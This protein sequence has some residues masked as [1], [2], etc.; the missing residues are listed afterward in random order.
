MAAL[1]LAQR[2]PTSRSPQRQ[3][4]SDCNRS[5]RRNAAVIDSRR[6]GIGL[7]FAQLEAPPAQRHGRQA[8]EGE[9]GA[10][11]ALSTRTLEEKRER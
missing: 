9:A 8:H 7:R 3:G 1:L 4:V 2:R 11:A 6:Q 10:A 5:A